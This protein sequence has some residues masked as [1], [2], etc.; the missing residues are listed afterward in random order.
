MI[1]SFSPLSSRI[2]H[3][4]VLTFSP[5]KT[6]QAAVATRPHSGLIL[7]IHA[8]ASIVS[9]HSSLNSCLSVTIGACTRRLCKFIGDRVKQFLIDD[10]LTS[11][12]RPENLS[13]TLTE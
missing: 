9:P 11:V 8:P 2:I 13:S 4:A 7:D 6:Q 10:T 5:I 1:P 12:S 3:Y